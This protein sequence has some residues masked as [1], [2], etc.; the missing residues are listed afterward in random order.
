MYVAW[1]D[2]RFARGRFALIGAV[3]A[4]ITLLVGFLSGL[5]GGLAAQ[6]VSAVLA[7]PADRLVL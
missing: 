2:L 4:L 5:T 3:V 7:L 1:R 6:N